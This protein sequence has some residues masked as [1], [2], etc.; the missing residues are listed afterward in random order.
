MYIIAVCI[1]I[2]KLFLNSQVIPGASFPAAKPG[3]R[4]VRCRVVLIYAAGLFPSIPSQLQTTTMNHFDHSGHEGMDHDM[5]G[6]PDH[7]GHGGMDMGGKCSMNML[8]C[9]QR[10]ATLSLRL[11]DLLT[12]T[13][14]LAL[15]STS[16]FV[17]MQEHTNH[18]HL[19]HLSTMAV[20]VFFS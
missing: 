2:W 15:S 7:G 20:R 4:R 5:P 3:L 13:L 14:A 1:D 10:Y 18:R 9:V 12:A 19:Y 16:S 6:M 8:W 17:L 11:H